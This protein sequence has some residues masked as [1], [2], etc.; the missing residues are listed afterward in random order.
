[1]NLVLRRNHSD[2]LA[3]TTA[4]LFLA[5][6]MAF[7][8]AFTEPKLVLLGIIFISLFLKFLRDRSLYLPPAIIIFYTTVIAMGFCWSIIG[9]LNA[10]PVEASNQALR[11]YVFWSILISTVL[12]Y[13]RYFD[14]FLLIHRSIILAGLTTSAIVLSFVVTQYLGIEIYPGWFKDAMWLRIGFHSGYVQVISHN[15]GPLLFIVPYLIVTALRRDSQPD[16]RVLVYVT[17]FLTLLTASLTGRRALWLVILAIPYLMI[18]FSII[19]STVSQIRQ[20]KMVM[21]LGV[22]GLV[23]AIFIPLSLLQEETLNY[24]WAAFNAEDERSI[25]AKFIL[26]AFLEAPIFGS[27]FG[28]EVG[29]VRSET[30]PWL[31]ELTY[32]QILFNFGV[33][34]VV[35]FSLLF[36]YLF[37]LACKV[38]KADQ[39]IGV[40]KG[41]MALLCGVF[42]I[43]VGAYSNPYLGSFDY[44]VMLSFFPLL[45]S[46]AATQELHSPPPSVVR[47]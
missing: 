24:L 9:L 36:A 2:V 26:R 46:F 17:L 27:G 1:M 12:I 16:H 19:T 32:H 31:F 10:N 13:I 18:G 30:S 38:I 39:N 29:Y 8:R 34:G 7:P 21:A 25:Q 11:L 47:M 6:T 41:G 35:L 43:L 15:V 20:P 3:R 14:A 23:L 33:F 42:G 22:L 45:A 44:L 37:I 5:S 40:A 28:G 4:V